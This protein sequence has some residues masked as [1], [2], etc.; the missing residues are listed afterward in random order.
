MSP[1]KMRRASGRVTL[2]TVLQAKITLIAATWLRMSS[3]IPKPCRL[4]NTEPTTPS[5]HLTKGPGGPMRNDSVC[6]ASP[7]PRP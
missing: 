3:P 5:E 1:P 6:E 7:T 4:Y 2:S